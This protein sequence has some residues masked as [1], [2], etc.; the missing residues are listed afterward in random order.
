[1]SASRWGLPPGLWEAGKGKFRNLSYHLFP[2]SRH[3][4]L[5][6]EPELFDR[7]ILGWPVKHDR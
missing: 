7:L 6:D 5:L 2:K 3:W 1:M 4:P